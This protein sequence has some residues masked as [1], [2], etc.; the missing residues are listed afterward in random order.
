M[1]FYFPITSW[2][3]IAGSGV[4]NYIY[5]RLNGK[6]SIWRNQFIAQIFLSGICFM[7]DYSGTVDIIS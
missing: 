6:K 7:N 3:L 2:P 5:G 4:N 1:S